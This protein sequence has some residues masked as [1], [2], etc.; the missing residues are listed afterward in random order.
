MV[1][2]KRAYEPPDPSDGVRIL[3]DRLWPRGLKR[4]GAELRDWLRDV[5]TSPELRRWYGHDPDRFTD[6]A[7]RYR[8]ELRDPSHAPALARLLDYVETEPVVTLVTATRDLAHAHTA[9]LV[10][11]IA[12]DRTTDAG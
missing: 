12:A 9:V 1:T 8:R 6:F 5:A 10:E 4:D 3:V 2:V 11:L 7:A